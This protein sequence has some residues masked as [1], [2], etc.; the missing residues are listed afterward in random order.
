MI[1]KIRQTICKDTGSR[2]ESAKLIIV[3]R[4]LALIMIFY[5]I[6]HGAFSFMAKDSDGLL[7]SLLSLILFAVVLGTSYRWTTFT[8]FCCLNVLILAW[9]IITVINFGWNI[10]VQHFLL[11]LLV[12]C[13]YAK[14]GHEVIKILYACFLFA[15]RISLYFYS[16]HHAPLLEVDSGT[17]DAMQILNT[18]AIFI[19]ISVIM[20]IFSRDSQ[21]LEGKLIEYN[22]QL[23]KQANTDTLTELSNRRS[24]TAYL[25]KLLRNPETPISICLC[26]ID[27]FKRVNDTY[28]HEMGDVVLKKVAEFFRTCLPSNCFISRWG[29]EE[30]LLIFPTQNGDEARVHLSTLSKK[31]KA[32]T[33]RCEDKTFHISMTFGLVEYDYV[34]DLDSIIKEADDKLYYG[35]E[36]GR[37]QIVF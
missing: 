25:E 2:N 24:T 27:L 19:T 14:Y 17:N 13:F 18:A 16:Q 7:F 35:K 15:I 22:E 28:G 31:M 37:D 6:I 8:T 3:I 34:S 23:M 11:T 30:F 26:D 20:Y 1:N 33:F 4:L 12:F 36:H 21:M 29:G 5:S 32:Y 10:G 9:I